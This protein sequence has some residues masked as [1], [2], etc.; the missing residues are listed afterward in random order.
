MYLSV[1]YVSLFSLLTNALV[2]LSS[3][4]ENPDDFI[5]LSREHIFLG[6]LEVWANAFKKSL[7][8]IY[9][10]HVVLFPA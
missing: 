8:R 3:N 6:I 7:T 4:D 9:L 10:L 1:L 2:S 5:L